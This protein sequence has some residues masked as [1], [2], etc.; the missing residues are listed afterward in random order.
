[1]EHTEKPSPHA[2]LQ[3]ARARYERYR[4]Q[5]NLDCRGRTSAVSQYD[6][7]PRRKS[8]KQLEQE[9]TG[10]TTDAIGL[11]KIWHKDQLT[12]R[13]QA[14]REM[15]HFSSARS[16]PIRVATAEG[17]TSIN[18]R[19]ASL[20]KTSKRHNASEKWHS[21]AHAAYQER[22]E[23]VASL[24]GVVSPATASDYIEREA[25]VAETEDEAKAI[26][27][28][29][30]DDAAERQRFW[31]MVEA[32]E[33]QGGE[34]LLT[35]DMSLAGSIA[36]SVAADPQCPPELSRKINTAGD[37][38]TI[39]VPGQD[40]IV[41]RDLFAQHGWHAKSKAGKKKSH[42]RVGAPVALATPG[43][44]FRDARAGRTQI[45]ANGELPSE[46][47][48][49]GKIRIAEQLHDWF[50]GRDLPVTVVVHAPDYRNHEEN[51]HFH[52]AAYDRPCRRFVNDRDWLRE[53]ATN[54]SEAERKAYEKAATIIGDPKLK[55]YEGEWDFLVP[56]N[57]RTKSRNARQSFPF[58]NNKDRDLNGDD[59][60]GDLRT[61]LVHWCN[62]E[63]EREGHER[64]Y[65]H[66]TYE[67][68]GIEK[69][70]DEH[71]GKQAAVLE[72]FGHPT[73]PSTANEERQWAFIIAKLDRE[74]GDGLTKVESVHRKLCPPPTDN[75]TPAMEARRRSA[76]QWRALV[77]N[78][79]D[80]LRAEGEL[81]QLI[82]RAK[83]RAM[84]TADACRKHVEAIDAG[85]APKAEERNRALYEKRLGIALE[86]LEGVACQFQQQN[87]D[88]EALKAERL[89]IMTLA[90]QVRR[91]MRKTSLASTEPGQAQ[92]PGG[93]A[94]GSRHVGSTEPSLRPVP[95][96]VIDLQKPEREIALRRL[97]AFARKNPA[98]AKV[99][100]R[101]DGKRQLLLDRAPPEL[102]MLATRY[103]SDDDLCRRV[104]LLRGPVA[105]G[106]M[107]E[108]ALVTPQPKQSSSAD[109]VHQ[110]LLRFQL[111]KTAADRRKAAV[112]IRSNPEALR[113]MNAAADPD[114]QLEQQR[115]ASQNA[116][117]ARNGG[118]KF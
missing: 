37:G 90:N 17:I 40:H 80:C 96:T 70:A 69:D 28:N 106:E 76:D 16:R 75:D 10:D 8:R 103:G 101:A 78:A 115:F 89:K 52:L 61:L 83:S 42:A 44:T 65:D 33:P 1:M 91:T 46:L 31:K 84:A 50:D 111:A 62:E 18:F 107:K 59:F 11:L 109:A 55:P 72:K 100:H 116:V 2:C 23:A 93:I 29:I 48:L 117:L 19:I 77:T 30:S 13:F 9:I 25:A 36:F 74:H 24:D 20:S 98:R 108:Q 38:E 34:N 79:Y 57:T 45:Q 94:S 6:E 102:M 47:S 56:W 68:M 97:T 66:R 63:L 12:P 104:D 32:I 85:R 54:A 51:W 73:A 110:L 7:L 118:Y 88:L 113:V 35:L 22:A 71:L 41:A 95:Q 99:L 58:K 39:S 60:V 64:R 92:S 67:L 53:P 27:S 14:I 15:P 49:A 114:W 81:E 21:A 112:S 86:H 105:P 26:F 82:A 43:I 5:G 87:Q 3:R 4:G